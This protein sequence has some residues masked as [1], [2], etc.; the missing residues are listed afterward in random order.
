[1][2]HFS[3]VKEYLWS[4]FLSV[5]CIGVLARELCGI[6]LKRREKEGNDKYIYVY[7]FLNR[8]E[9][10]RYQVRREGS[11]RWEGRKGERNIIPFTLMYYH[12]LFI[13]RFYHCACINISRVIVQ[14]VTNWMR[15][16]R[17][18]THEWAD[19]QIL[20][21]TPLKRTSCWTKLPEHKYT[22]TRLFR[23]KNVFYFF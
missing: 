10:Q 2:I 3:V 22:Y 20:T 1:M 16:K 18:F 11:F 13:C 8:N 17:D 23:L 9:L 4:V 19:W 21:L 5:N 15:T 14:R 7:I 6:M 12:K